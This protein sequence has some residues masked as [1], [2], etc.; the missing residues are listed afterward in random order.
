MDISS[1][2]EV[3]EQFS[4]NARKILTVAQERAELSHSRHLGS[5]HIL[6]GMLAVDR[7]V[8]FSIL[9]R[10]GLTLEKVEILMSF[11]RAVS[12]SVSRAKL[13]GAAKRILERAVTLAADYG[14]YYIGSEHLLAA[15][16]LDKKNQAYQILEEARLDLQKLEA[17]VKSL[18]SEAKKVRGSLPSAGR[19][20]KKSLLEDF[21]VDLTQLAREGKLDPV[22]GREKEITRLIQI[23][24][25]RTKNNP[26]LVGDPGV[27]KTAIVE[28]LANRIALGKIPP[29]LCNK[30]VLVVNLS[31][32]VAGTKYRGEFEDRMN[33]IINEVRERSDVILFVDEVH[34]LVGAGSAE[35]SMDAANI[36]KPALARGEL[37]MIG[38]TTLEEY[39]KHIEKDSALERR[40]QP[41]TVAEPSAKETLKILSGIKGRY[42]SFHQVVFDDSALK[43]AVD[44]SQ[45]YINDR[46]LPDKAIDL[47]DE[48]ASLV[49]IDRSPD[50]A[51]KGLERLEEKLQKVRLS[52]EKAVRMRHYE[53]AAR[54][55]NEEKKLK[56]QLFRQRGKSSPG[57]NRAGWPSVRAQ[58]VARIVSSWTGIPLG[59]LSV[60][61]IVS[62][63]DLEKVL[64]RRVVG[65]RE[66]TSAVAAAIKRSRMQIGNPNRPLGSFLFLGPTGVGKT[67]LAKVLAEEVFRDKKALIRLDMSE[68]MERHNVSRLTGAPAGYVGFEE[69][70]R[71][72]EAVRQHPYAV[73]LFDEIEKAHPEVMNILLQILEE[74]ALSDAKGKKVSFKNTIIILTSNI[75]TSMFNRQ[76]ALGF[77][78]E[79]KG[80]VA[81]NYAKLV[82]R[83]MENVKKELKP[84]FI[85]RLD[86]IIV[87]KSLGKKQIKSIVE[88]Q[89]K[90]LISRL[91]KNKII[92]KIEPAV[93]ELLADKGFEPASGARPIRR[94]IQTEIEDPLA[95]LLLDKEEGQVRVFKASRRGGKIVIAAEFTAP[96]SV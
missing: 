23:L 85:N 95:E 66:A 96:V 29:A 52:K 84:E 88:L 63:K 36:L 71:L 58:D 67:E 65:Q 25:R 86:K 18:L 93:K 59:E 33:K 72:T 69:G 57:E 12:P 87:F 1:F 64:S 74:G 13:S 70:G 4:P 53:E 43:A 28:G 3:F 44:L 6:L 5:E 11:E 46:F 83:V 16:L 81:D 94:L 79:G 61:E 27:G 7:G 2:G 82:E 24:N 50:L 62:L 73:V 90:E 39:R 80:A 45:R 41:I 20:E 32:L 77:S 35:G 56:G 22:I 48:A 92:L 19:E 42:E 49:S 51:E 68:F 31:S 78:A 91:K 21:S 76:A 55:Q 15:I 17:G 54:Y 30:R 34:S 38:A 14:C 26:V 89:L 40:F 8:A 9:T 10:A 75:G 60:G 37:Q 47:L